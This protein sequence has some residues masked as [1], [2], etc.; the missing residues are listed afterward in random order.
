MSDPVIDVWDVATF[1]PEVVGLLNDHA[2]LIR[3]YHARAREN[4]IKRELSDRTGP[5]PENPFAEGHIQLSEAVMAVMGRK[6][7]G[8]WHYTRLTDP[9]VDRLRLGGIALA[10]SESIRARL[11]AQVDAGA[12]EV[13]VANAIHAASPFQRGQS[14]VRSGRFWMV[15]HPRDVKDSGVKP[16]LGSWGGEGVYFWLADPEH[17][18]LVASIGRPRVLEVAAPLSKSPHGYSPAEAV[19]AAFARSMGCT[20]EAKT[21]DF[22]VTEPLPPEAVLS[23]HTAGEIKFEA[24]GRDYPA[25]YSD[26]D[27]CPWE[28]IAAEIE[29]RRR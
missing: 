9:E 6:T 26:A 23:I 22:Y 2:D 20:S 1:D 12:F 27:L 3:D 5:Y 10:S 21:F 18:A 8:G 25:N 7:I 29:R 4:L 19:L 16:L 14:D 13:G 17:E 15:S 24:I 11:D 28:A